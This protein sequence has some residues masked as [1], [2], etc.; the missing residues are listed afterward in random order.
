MGAGGIMTLRDQ[1]PHDRFGG[2]PSPEVKAQQAVRERADGQPSPK[3]VRAFLESEG[4]FLQPCFPKA[5]AL[6]FVQ[7][8]SAQRRS[9]EQKG[10]AAAYQL[11]PQVTEQCHKLPTSRTGW[12]LLDQLLERLLAL[13]E[14]RL[15]LGAGPRRRQG[16]LAFQKISLGFLGHGIA[17]SSVS[18]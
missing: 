4:S 14:I 16:L 11:L 7:P 8:L 9:P 15:Q 2:V 13:L 5:E 3:P 12:R 18:S 1:S 17:T 10:Q 6:C